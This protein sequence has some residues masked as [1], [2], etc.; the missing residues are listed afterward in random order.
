[1]F[2]KCRRTETLIKDV[3]FCTAALRPI[4]A[5]SVQMNGR[6]TQTDTVGLTMY[7]S[8]C[9]KTFEHSQPKSMKATHFPWGSQV[10]GENVVQNRELARLAHFATMPSLVIEMRQTIDDGIWEWIASQSKMTAAFL[11]ILTERRTES[12]H[13]S[14]RTE[15]PSEKC[16][17]SRQDKSFSCSSLFHTSHSMY[18][19][20]NAMADDKEGTPFS[21]A[22]TQHVQSHIF[23]HL[24]QLGFDLSN[25]CKCP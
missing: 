15:S 22:T 12:E 7:K 20:I 25:Q 19:C 16:L 14:C 8:N 5:K 24:T 2:F 10:T 18:W 1:M 17:I 23:T 9:I 6:N 21:V 11:F 3:F 4:K 13:C